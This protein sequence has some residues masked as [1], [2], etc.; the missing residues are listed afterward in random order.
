MYDLSF[1]NV[2][3]LLFVWGVIFTFVLKDILETKEHL[4]PEEEEK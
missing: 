3:I 4:E 1:S 2:I